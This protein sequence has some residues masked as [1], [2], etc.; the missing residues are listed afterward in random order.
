MASAPVDRVAVVAAADP[1]VAW[2]AA[3]ES[4]GGLGEVAGLVVAEDLIGPVV[5]LNRV[6]AAVAVEDVVGP[7]AGEGVV[8]LAAEE[9]V[10]AVAASRA[11]A[12]AMQ[13]VGA[14]GTGDL[15]VAGSAVAEDSDR[16]RQVGREDHDVVVGPGVEEDRVDAG[17]VVAEAHL[18]VGDLAVAVAVFPAGVVG[19]HDD[20]AGG[21]V[22]VDLKLFIAVAGLAGQD[23]AGPRAHVEHERLRHAGGQRLVGGAGIVVVVVGAAH[24]GRERRFHRRAGDQVPLQEPHIEQL[25]ALLPERDEADERHRDANLD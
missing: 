11:A 5:A 21:G 23:E 22:V 4:G 18:V 20:L 19:P 24:D 14:G 17:G 6:A 7:A 25:D 12:V 13:G 1:V 3:A 2:G 16:G 15:V 10:F 8:R 9:P